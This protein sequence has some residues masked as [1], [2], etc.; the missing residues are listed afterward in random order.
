MTVTDF[1]TQTDTNSVKDHPWGRVA[2]CYSAVGRFFPICRL[3][4]LTEGIY[5]GNPQTPYEQ[6]E[7]NQLD[8]LLD[9]VGPGP[10]RAGSTYT[11]SRLRVWYAFRANSTARSSV[12]RGHHLG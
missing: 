2:T 12:S 3:F 4:D 9:H 1:H 10:M 7:A 5:H 11:G 8:Y 6:A